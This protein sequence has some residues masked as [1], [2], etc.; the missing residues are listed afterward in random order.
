MVRWV[1]RSD[2]RG[3]PPGVWPHSTKIN[4]VGTAACTTLLAY[5]NIS[6]CDTTPFPLSTRKLRPWKRWSNWNATVCWTILHWLPWSSYI[7]VLSKSCQGTQQMWMLCWN[8]NSKIWKAESQFHFGNKSVHAKHGWLPTNKWNLG[9]ESEG[10][11]I[12]SSPR[13]VQV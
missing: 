8:K 12:G 9:V 11:G 3:H 10:R 7:G 6:S 13:F 4:L 1:S 5:H 2:L